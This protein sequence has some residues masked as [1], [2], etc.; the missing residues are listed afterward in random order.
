[1]NVTRDEAAQALSEVGAASVQIR[2]LRYYRAS[3]WLLIMWGLIWVFANTVTY[4]DS[5]NITWAWLPAIPGAIAS[6]WFGHV[7]RLRNSRPLSPEQRAEQPNWFYIAMGIWLSAVCFI[8]VA[9]PLTMEQTNAI[10]SLTI[11]GAYF[12]SGAW[13]GWRFALVGIV[14]MAAIMAG[15]LLMKE[16]YF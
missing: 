12:V 16:Y 2:R 4:I 5:F 14:T 7:Y 9:W 8:I 11:G 6:W 3:A 10:I 15:Y 1:M 13:L